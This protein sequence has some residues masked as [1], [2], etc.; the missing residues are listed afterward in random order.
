MKFLVM[1]RMGAAPI[2]PQQG[3]AIMQ[4]AKEWMNTAI[5]E[6]GADCHYVVVSGQAG[7]TISNADS[8]EELMAQLL[9]YPLYP[10][11]SW[12]I[13]PLCDWSQSYDLFIE[14]WK[15]MA[16]QQA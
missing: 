14:F 15:K 5:A 6:G 13:T 9:S 12:E 1:G 10:F 7:F 11:L 2:P 16:A 4:A 3:A 8:H